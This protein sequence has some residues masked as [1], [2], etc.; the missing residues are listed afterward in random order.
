MLVPPACLHSIALFCPQILLA[1]GDGAVLE[2][3]S[4]NFFAVQDGTLYTAGEG[5][6]LGTIRDLA[7][8]VS[9]Q[10]FCVTRIMSVPTQACTSA[11]TVSH[12][13]C[14]RHELASQPLLVCCACSS[15]LQ[16]MLSMPPCLC[17]RSPLS[18]GRADARCTC[19]ARS[20]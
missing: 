2:G 13:T 10:Q 12:C 5:V 8:K 1:Q 16:P 14:M 9:A 4:S 3:M 19:S 20:C 18:A 7:I 6:L 15:Q 17:Q 11:C